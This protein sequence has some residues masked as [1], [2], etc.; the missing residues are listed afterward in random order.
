MQD[1]NWISQPSDPTLRTVISANSSGLRS[2][3]SL[4]LPYDSDLETARSS[5]PFSASSRSPF[6]VPDFCDVSPWT[7]RMLFL[8]AERV[9]GFGCCQTHGCTAERLRRGGGS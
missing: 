7:R 5:P 2:M 9:V 6:R 4:L 1:V 3:S 8:R